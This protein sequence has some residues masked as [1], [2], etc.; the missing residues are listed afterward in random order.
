MR[1]QAWKL[2]FVFSTVL[3]AG[4]VL[5]PRRAWADLV[6]YDGLVALVV[7]AILGGVWL[8]RPKRPAPWLLFALGHLL[9]FCGELSFWYLDTTGQDPFPSYADYFYLSAYPAL[10]LG[11]LLLVR[12]HSP[13]RDLF[14][15]LDAAILAAAAGLLSWVYLME[16]YA[17]DVESSTSD[18]VWSLAYPV[19]DLVLLAITVRLLFAL[20]VKTWTTSLLSAW[21]AFT[22]G[23]DVLYGWLIL[24]GTYEAGGLLDGFWLVGYACVGAAALHPSMRAEVE[25]GRR[26]RFRVG[27]GR[28][29]VLGLAAIVPPLVL[30][31]QQLQASDGG[32]TRF[33]PAIATLAIFVLVS[34][35]MGGLVGTVRR[36]AER[37]GQEQFEAMVEHSADVIS[38]ID[39]DLNVAYVSPAIRSMYGLDAADL[40]GQPVDQLV[41]DEDRTPLRAQLQRI[42]NL[43]EGSTSSFSA[44]FTRS[45]GAR[46]TFEAV[47][48]NLRAS[49]GGMVV[50]I[51]D[52][53]A[54]A[55]LESQLSHRAFHDS[56]TDL[57]NRALFV[58]RVEHSLA[59]HQRGG[60]DQVAV[61]FIDVD[62]FK[63]V[64]DAL[65]HAAGDDLLVSIGKRLLLCLRTG[66]T[67]ARLGGD[68]FAVLVDGD[69]GLAE[70]IALADRILEVLQLPLTVGDLELG[71]RVS[72]GIATG[73]ENSTTQSLLRDADIAMYD[74]KGSGKGCYA[75]FDPS[76][77]EAASEHL[78]LRTDLA[79]ALD[80]G[81]LR[82][83]YQPIVAL[84]TEE[85]IGAEALLRWEHPER[86]NITPDQFIPIAEQ[87]GLIVPIGRWVLQQACAQAAT[88]QADGRPR[89]VSVNASGAQF[90]DVALVEDIVSALDDSG[91][92]PEL[93]T[94]E[95]TETVLM[96]DAEKAAGILDMVS[97][98]GVRLAIDDFGTGYCSLAY[99]RNFP[100]DVIKIDRAFVSELDDPT[101][102][103]GLAENILA[104]TASL[105][106]PAVAEGIEHQAQADRLSGM[107]CQY[108]QG[109]LFARPLEATAIADVFGTTGQPQHISASNDVRG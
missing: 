25:H 10:A 47:I 87:S 97:G 80:R 79:Q 61:L 23:A 4:Y 9:L 50:T 78:A 32:N 33:V 101:R 55:E 56:L 74:A 16:P 96:D 37:R 99:V 72:I 82:V 36:L 92:A 109:F 108:G 93:L 84:D 48:A 69:A 68:E 71:I 20:Q 39:D 89:T 30:I 40:V 28:M 22:I 66:D 81:E 70:C 35:R 24:Q 8:H 13:V 106:V 57:P 11:L 105:D 12:E 7:A 42:A 18:K 52:V 90:R 73:N 83:V 31:G 5:A 27:N 19:M 51:N 38:V 46:G 15:G 85:F 21:L 76:M 107:N 34:I 102:T 1:R 67:I 64:N 88:W 77:R 45:D 41:I 59:R 14:G 49:A 103:G 98:L 29:L 86:G 94:I 3:A 58:D 6:V 17:T 43:D 26:D 62:D 2:L 53:T 75:V 60:A 91:L 63:S 104:L 65:G 44:Q 54:R 100:V 95:I